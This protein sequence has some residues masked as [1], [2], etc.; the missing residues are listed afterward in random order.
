MRLSDFF[1]FL[2][3]FRPALIYEKNF[4]ERCKIKNTIIILNKIKLWFFSKIDE[5]IGLEEESY[6]FSTFYKVSR[7]YG[8]I[9]ILYSNEFEIFTK[10][11]YFLSILNCTED[12]VIGKQSRYNVDLL[13]KY[14]PLLEEQEELKEIVSNKDRKEIVWTNGIEYGVVDSSVAIDTSL[15]RRVMESER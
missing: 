8:T 2:Q 7:K 10:G 12:F 15:L 3:T 13:C 5:T 14:I 6:Y 4:F 1:I 11:E 9:A